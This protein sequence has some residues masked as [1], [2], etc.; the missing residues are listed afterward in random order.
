M[1]TLLRDYPL[2]SRPA[3]AGNV[4][5]R[6]PSALLLLDI[7]VAAPRR[8]V[9]RHFLSLATV[10]ML[11]STSLLSSVGDDWCMLYFYE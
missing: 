11:A 3:V 2:A 10:I 1:A 9:G 6:A 8:V 4:P 5:A 7:L